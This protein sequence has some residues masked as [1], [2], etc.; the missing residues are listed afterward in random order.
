MLDEKMK[1]LALREYGT[2]RY[3]EAVGFVFSTGEWLDFGEGHPTRAQDHR[4]V[5][6]FVPHDDTAFGARSRAMRDWMIRVQAARVMADRKST[7]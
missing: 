7:V 5:A 2:T 6:Q 4:N 3:I 1:A